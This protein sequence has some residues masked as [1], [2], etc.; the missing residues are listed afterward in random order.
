[1]RNKMKQ[2]TE[3]KLVYS[4]WQIT[5]L[6]LLRVLIGWH[7]LYEGLIK[8]YTPEWTAK[9][10][11]LGAVGPF[12]SLFKGMA[13]SATILSFIDF[14]NE[15]GLVLIGLSLFVGVLTR[16]FIIFAMG[17]LVTY[18][19]SYPPFSGINLTEYVEGN[20][21]IVNKN[22]IEMAALFVLFVFP[23]SHITGLDHFIFSKKT[24]SN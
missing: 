23:T 13:N 9:E 16:P 12:A 10:Y 18:Y 4:T 1:M 15:W 5:G 22:L 17:F 24:E 19:L 11:L 14:A 7:F 6:T 2:N 21:W 3:T 8:V 20:Y